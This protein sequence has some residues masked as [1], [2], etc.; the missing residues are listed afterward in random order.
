MLYAYV[1]NYFSITIGSMKP[2]E[3]SLEAKQNENWQNPF[4]FEKNLNNY[5]DTNKH[6]ILTKKSSGQ[7]GVE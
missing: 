5:E 7:Q 3:D 6:V 2:P 4:K 1:G